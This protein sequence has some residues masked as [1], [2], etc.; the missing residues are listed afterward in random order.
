M[1]VSLCVSLCV[2]L[3]ICHSVC[4]CTFF[5]MNVV[6]SGCVIVGVFVIVSLRVAYD[7]VCLS[8]FAF[9]CQRVYVFVFA[10]I[11]LF[12]CGILCVGA[13]LTLH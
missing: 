9:V 2:L 11:G 10:S 6:V 3:C 5:C 4:V 13:C 12:M 1:C 8:L 7:R